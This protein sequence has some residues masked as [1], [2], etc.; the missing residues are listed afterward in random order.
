MTG[1][2]ANPRRRAAVF[3]LTAL[4]GILS[5]AS[6]Y[7]SAGVR[8]PRPI[9]GGPFEASGVAYVPGTTGVLFADDHESRAVFWMELGPDG[10]QKGRGEAGLVRFRFDP[11]SGR[12][13]GGE[14]VE[15]PHAGSARARPKRSRLSRP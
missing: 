3:V 5:G 10:T 12:V 1:K 14:Q 7:S 6:W 4:T 8:R 13:T 11:H 15:A 9:A 2:R